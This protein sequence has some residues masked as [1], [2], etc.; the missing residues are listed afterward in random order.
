MAITPVVREHRQ[1]DKKA[2]SGNQVS[3]MPKT[4]RRCSR[5]QA[6]GD[7][8][9]RRW[10]RG[11]QRAPS[12]QVSCR[13]AGRTPSPRRRSSPV[14]AR[15]VVTTAR[16]PTTLYQRKAML[17]YQAGEDYG[18]TGHHAPKRSAAL[19]TWEGDG[20]DEHTEHPAVE[21]RPE[22][23]HRLDQRPHVFDELGRDHRVKAPDE[24]GRA[25][26]Q[27]LLPLTCRAHGVTPIE[28]D[29]ADGAKGASSQRRTRTSLRP[30]SSR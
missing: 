23:V 6:L 24:R 26:G 11:A 18:L 3:A 7:R 16:Q 30:G 25:G 27:E 28:V 21:E 9:D 29:D 10:A 19:H 20:K 1:G 13:S 12:G 17:V 15:P 2:L 8:L 22:Q 5:A 14:T 4:P